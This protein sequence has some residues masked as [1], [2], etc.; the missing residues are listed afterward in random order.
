MNRIHYT[1]CP[2]CVHPGIKKITTTT[3]HTVSGEVFEIWECSNCSLRFTQDV[4]DAISIGKYYQSE[5]YISHSNTSAGIINQLYH[6]VRKV[7]IRSK[8]RIVEK[9][10]SVSKGKLLDVGAGTGVFTAAMKQAGWDVTALEPDETARGIAKNNFGLKLLKAEELFNF[11]HPQFDVITLWHVL[12]HIHPI[13][14]YLSHLRK[15]V[16]A[17]GTILIAVPNYPSFDASVYKNNW[18][19]YDVPR[20][21]YHFS[22]ASMKILLTNHGM[23]V[24]KLLPMWFDSFYVSMLS[25]KYKTGKNNLLKGFI[26]G[27]FSNLKAIGDF[28]RCSSVIYV[29]KCP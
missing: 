29:V 21:L 16:R 13:K 3:D 15:I 4:P 9:Y 26:N 25:E 5:N 12:E 11:Q 8:R 2:S 18:A 24:T 10:S 17:N 22:P 19:A 27:L 23:Q 1:T 28:E 20:H 7:T 14:E 6:T